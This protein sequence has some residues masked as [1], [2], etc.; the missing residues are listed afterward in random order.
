MLQIY[1][2]MFQNAQIIYIKCK[3]NYYNIIIRVHAL[4]IVTW[5]DATMIYD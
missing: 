4:V 3:S 5:T 1:S 2:I